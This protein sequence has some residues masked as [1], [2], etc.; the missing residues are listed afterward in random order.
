MRL[1]FA[2]VSD[3]RWALLLSGSIG[4][5]WGIPGRTKQVNPAKPAKYGRRIFIMSQGTIWTSI[6]NSSKRAETAAFYYA[7][8][9]SA[10]SAQ[11]CD[12]KQNDTPPVR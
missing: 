9:F 6:Q 1:I 5:G 10:F 12:E 11:K 8:S 2:D 7:C 3:K 4:K